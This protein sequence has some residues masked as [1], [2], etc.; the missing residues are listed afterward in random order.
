MLD[1]LSKLPPILKFETSVFSSNF[2]FHSMITWTIRCKH[3]FSFHD[4][5]DTFDIFLHVFTV[6]FYILFFIFDARKMKFHILWILFWYWRS[7]IIPFQCFFVIVFANNNSC[8]IIIF[9]SR[10]PSSVNHILG[11]QKFLIN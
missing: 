3:F 1:A 9:H 7:V 5:T 6:I 10:W 11:I 4:T 2:T 8:K